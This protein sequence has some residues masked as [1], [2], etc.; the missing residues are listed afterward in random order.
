MDKILERIE[1]AIEKLLAELESNPI[2]TSIKLFIW[3]YIAKTIW[4]EIKR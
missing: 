1:Q 4:K 2:K 3:Y